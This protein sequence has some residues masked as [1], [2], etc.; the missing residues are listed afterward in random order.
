MLWDGQNDPYHD[1]MQVFAAANGFP[2][3]STPGDHV[4]ALIRPDV[5]TV[6]SIRAFLDRASGRLAE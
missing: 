3:V 6:K 4:G 5:E 1:P 2:F